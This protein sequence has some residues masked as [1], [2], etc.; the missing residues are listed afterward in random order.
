MII[1]DLLRE[2]KELTKIEVIEKD[3]KG[4][5]VKLLDFKQS[6]ITTQDYIVVNNYDYYLIKALEL[7]QKFNNKIKTIDGLMSLRDDIRETI[8]HFLGE[9]GENYILNNLKEGNYDKDPYCLNRLNMY[10]YLNS[11]ENKK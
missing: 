5:K 1:D 9:E 6:E 3:E 10:D 7:N 4:A 8:N 11:L 2:L